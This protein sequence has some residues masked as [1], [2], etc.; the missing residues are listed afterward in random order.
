MAGI[1]ASG[2]HS[3]VRQ[4]AAGDAL[5]VAGYLDGRVHRVIRALAHKVMVNLAERVR[6]L[7]ERVY[8]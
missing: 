1:F 5:D 2:L 7:D 8:G 4:Q 3:A 6:E